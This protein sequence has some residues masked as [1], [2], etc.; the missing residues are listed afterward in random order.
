MYDIDRCTV[1]FSE[2]TRKKVKYNFAIMI[3][4]VILVFVLK[5]LSVCNYQMGLLRDLTLGVSHN[6][7]VVS[8]IFQGV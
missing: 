6:N 8:I 1:L 5:I 2:I 7:Y 3:V 4:I